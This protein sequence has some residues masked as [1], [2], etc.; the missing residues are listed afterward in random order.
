[1]GD[2]CSVSSLVDILPD[3]FEEARFVGNRE[4]VSAILGDPPESCCDSI[5]QH[6]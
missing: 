3:H 2:A 1:M 5:H 6:H 4:G